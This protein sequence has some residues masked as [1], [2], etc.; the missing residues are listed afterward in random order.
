MLLV[1]DVVKTHL[2]NLEPHVTLDR[3]I[4][5]PIA[6]TKCLDHILAILQSPHKL[7]S[8][9]IIMKQIE[10]YVHCFLGHFIAYCRL[11]LKCVLWTEPGCSTTSLLHEI[12]TS[13]P[14]H[15]PNL[16]WILIHDVKLMAWNNMEHMTL[17][18]RRSR[19]VSRFLVFAPQQL[20]MQFPFLAWH[21][22][23]WQV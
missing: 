22:P 4:V 20:R 9:A 11:V 18:R 1:E 19:C 16:S 5:C 14:L 15:G 2:R 17:C 8:M 3:E 10:S 7:R 12:V 21:S 6:L 23:T 13:L